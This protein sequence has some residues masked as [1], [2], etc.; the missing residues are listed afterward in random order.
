[1]QTE[2]VNKKTYPSRN[3]MTPFIYFTRDNS[4]SIFLPAFGK[5][6][7]VT[8]MS[9]TLDWWINAAWV[10]DLGNGTGIEMFGNA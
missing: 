2:S 6:Q 8:D 1:M 5:I 9:G 3:V 10:L 4:A 7:K